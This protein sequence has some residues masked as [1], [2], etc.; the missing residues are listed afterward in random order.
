MKRGLVLLALAAVGAILALR[1]FT[2]LMDAGAAAEPPRPAAFRFCPPVTVQ[3]VDLPLTDAALRNL[4]GNVMGRSATYGE[5]ERQVQIHVGFDAL[6]ALEDLDLS[7]LTG[8]GPVVTLLEG[9]ALAGIT[10]LLAATWTDPGRTA[11]CG[12]VTMV[13]SGLTQVEFGRLWASASTDARAADLRS[14]R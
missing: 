1:A 12:R 14:S 10:P 11:P 7:P 4:G 2:A 13:S 6:E 8:S 5:A 9:R 3:A